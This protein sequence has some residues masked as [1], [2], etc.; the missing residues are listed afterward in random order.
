[1]DKVIVNGK[2]LKFFNLNKLGDKRL[3]RL[4]Y[5]IRILLENSIRNNDQFVYK[6]ST[7]EDVLSWSKT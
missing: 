5:S 3:E 2:D 6:E 1:M 7:T 4:P